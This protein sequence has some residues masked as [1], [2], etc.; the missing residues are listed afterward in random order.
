MG[1]NGR[2]ARGRTGLE[3]MLI[4]APGQYLATPSTT[5]AT[6]PA[7]IL[8]RSSRVMPGLR[9]TPA[10]MITKSHPVNAASSSSGPVWPVVTAC[11]RTT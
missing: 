10:G 2:A 11:R 7:L 3:I 8:K 9:G 5:P 4:M 6:M 1:V